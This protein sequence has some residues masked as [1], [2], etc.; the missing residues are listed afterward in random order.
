MVPVAAFFMSK[1]T[2]VT[3]EEFVSVWQKS[4]NIDTVIE[5]TGLSRGAVNG[6]AAVYR[7]KGVPLKKMPRA[8]GPRIDYSELASLAKKL[9]K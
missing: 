1:T 3:P 7:R 4:P 6:R 2:T 9:A 5:E 8:N